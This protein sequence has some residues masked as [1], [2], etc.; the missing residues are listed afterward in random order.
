MAKIENATP[1]NISGSYSRLFGSD[2]LGYL[3]SKVH[4]ASVSSGNELEKLIL[5]RVQRI[6]DLDEFLKQ[7]IM[8]DGIFIVPRKQIKKCSVLNSDTTPDFLIFKR[9]DG[10]QNCYVIELKDGHVFDSK[11]A[12]ADSQAIY[13]F[14]ENNVHNLKYKIKA[15]FCCFNQDNRQSI[16]EGLKK[17]ISLEEAITGRKFCDL[18]EIDYDEI[19]DI[20]KNDQPQNFM[21]FLSE[22]VNIKEVKETLYQ[23]MKNPDG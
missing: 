21:F 3:I 8:P 1:E 2:K 15:Y 13:T 20:R 11:K 9:G 14:I 12:R 23:L 7:E 10:E 19:V 16:Y 17:V 5:E 6:D 18:L 22:L 4:S